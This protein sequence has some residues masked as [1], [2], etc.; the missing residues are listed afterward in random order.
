MWKD[1]PVLQRGLR[2]SGTS[3]RIERKSEVWEK[4]GNKEF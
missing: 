1:V 2:A 3:L 4:A